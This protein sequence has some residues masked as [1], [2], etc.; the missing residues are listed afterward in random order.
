MF[1]AAPFALAGGQ[2]ATGAAG[3]KSQ[4]HYG[5]SQ[6]GMKDHQAISATVEE[7]DQEEKSLSLRLDD[8]KTVDLQVS[9]EMLSTL[10]QG[11]SVEVSIRKA[12]KGQ[13]PGMG[14]SQQSQ[15]GSGGMPQPGQNR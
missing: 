1:I 9:D 14:G 15:P 4:Q 5:Q 7:V 12:D 8:G 10:Q 11:D 2:S 3:K 6:T 13:M